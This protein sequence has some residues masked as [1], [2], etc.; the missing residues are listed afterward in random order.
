M[1]I[2]WKIDIFLLESQVQLIEQFRTRIWKRCAM[3]QATFLKSL[4]SGDIL[5]ADG[6]TG[7]NL[8]QRGL[9]MG[10]PGEVW[11]FEHP[12][13]IKRLHKDFIEAGSDIIL[14]CT[15]G[16][17]SIRL[18]GEGMENRAVELNKRAAVLAR[19]VVEGNDTLVAGS[20]GPTGQMLKPLGTL[21]EDEAFIAFADQARALTEAGVD[22]LLLETHFDL[23]EAII[24][25][26]AARS[27]SSLPLVCSFSY[28]RG[29]RTMMGVSPSQ[30]AAEIGALDVSVLGINCGRSLDDNLNALKELRTV[31]K[32][33]IWFKPNAGMPKIDDEGKTIYDVTPEEMGSRVSDWTAAGANVVGG[34]CGSS[35]EHIRKV[36]LAA[37]KK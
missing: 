21:E 18:D 36:A 33:P 16:G 25:V 10:K 26:K 4:Q 37:K 3:S 9:S 30:M 27:V 13:E 20:M 15:F 19:E 14:T 35:P 29:T 1:V 23:G 8:Q 24:A 28:D 34:C 32:L 22:L 7:T 12:E 2:G 31:T 5:V 11:V 6:A 17:T